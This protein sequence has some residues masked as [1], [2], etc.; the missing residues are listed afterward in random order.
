VRLDPRS[1]LLFAGA[2]CWCNG[3]YFPM[4]ADEQA[5]LVALAD[6]RRLGG[7][8]LRAAQAHSP[9]A[10]RSTLWPMLQ[11]WFD[12]GWLRLGDDALSD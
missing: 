5:T 4:A 9:D 8:A 12:D 7:A 10:W 2:D 1:R 3:E 6:R 11:Q